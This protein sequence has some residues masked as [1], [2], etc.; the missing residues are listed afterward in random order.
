MYE[1]I[2]SNEARNQL[3]K[4]NDSQKERIG[5]ALERIRVRP[6][7]FVK[8]LRSSKFYRLRV[9]HFRIILEIKDNQLLIHVLDIGERGNIYRKY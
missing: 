2:F 8:R 4:L 9:D 6:Y 1:I 3:V 5:Y 7:S